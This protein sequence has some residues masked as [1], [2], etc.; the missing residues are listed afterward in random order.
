MAFHANEWQH[1]VSGQ[2]RT[3][4]FAAEARA[5]T[6]DFQ[7][8]DVGHVPTSMSHL[9]ENAGSTPLRFLELFKSARFM[10]VGAVDGSDAIRVV[11]AR[12][13]TLIVNS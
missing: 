9:I 10:D 7:A 11:Q 12:I 3:P 13:G 8:G 4:V 5:R 1:Y 2:G 6:F